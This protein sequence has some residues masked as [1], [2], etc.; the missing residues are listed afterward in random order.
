MQTE[1][2]E[3]PRE[4]CPFCEGNEGQTP[5]EISASRPD[6]GDANTSGWSTRVV[7]NKYP[8][9]EQNGSARY[10]DPLDKVGD[11]SGVDLFKTDNAVGS[12]ELIVHTPKHKLT[13]ATLTDEELHA[14]LQMWSARI[15]ANSDDL[16][17]IIE[18]E[19]G[20][21]EAVLF[22]GSWLTVERCLTPQLE[23]ADVT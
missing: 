4:G 8:L 23:L 5:Q 6:D 22:M 15:S 7:P 18:H 19:D 21:L 20:S 10:S 13:M 9:L 2:D 16:L 17:R 1:T 12:H 14:S 11:L 3:E